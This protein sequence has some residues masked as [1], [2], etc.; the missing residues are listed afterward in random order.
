VPTPLTSPSKISSYIPQTPSRPASTQLSPAIPILKP[1]VLVLRR[2]LDPRTPNDPFDDWPNT[3]LEDISDLHHAFLTVESNKEAC[4]FLHAQSTGPVEDVQRSLLRCLDATR[5][6]R[7]YLTPPT[8]TKARTSSTTVRPGQAADALVVL[9]QKLSS[10]QLITGL[11]AKQ[12]EQ[13]AIDI[14]LD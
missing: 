5:T 13:V 9:S 12:L 14:R 7:L 8:K 4:Q 2:L 10:L 3:P 6:L 1:L 11:Q